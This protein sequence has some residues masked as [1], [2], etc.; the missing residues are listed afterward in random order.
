ME[1]IDLRSLATTY[2]YWIELHEQYKKWFRYY[3]PCTH[4]YVSNV[5]TIADTITELDD[6]NV[7]VEFRTIGDRGQGIKDVY[8]DKIKYNIPLDIIT[9]LEERKLIESDMR[10]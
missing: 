4:Q 10:V 3:D 7:I 9:V 5:S 8:I 6:Y 1:P 2:N